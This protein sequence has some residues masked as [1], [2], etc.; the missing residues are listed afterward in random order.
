MRRRN[1][2]HSLSR[3]LI[4]S[5]HR[6][7]GAT[8]ASYRYNNHVKRAE[9]EPMPDCR[10]DA[11][12]HDLYT[13]YSR[14]LV[15]TYFF[16]SDLSYLYY[17]QVFCQSRTGR[18]TYLPNKASYHITLKLLQ[19]ANTQTRRRQHWCLPRCLRPPYPCNHNE[20]SSKMNAAF[21]AWRT[22]TQRGLLFGVRLCYCRNLCVLQYTW[23]G[24][25]VGV[26]SNL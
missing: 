25:E 10:C 17:F 20:C 5:A 3:D 1:T 22:R 13:L 12:T 16:F 11:C 4:C 15:R 26:F 7:R 9:A 14:T 21:S 18:K 2:D 19:T 23:Y 8:F 24:V 6:W